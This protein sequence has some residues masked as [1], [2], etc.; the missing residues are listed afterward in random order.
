VA[1]TGDKC[2]S[3][4]GV[5]WFVFLQESTRIYMI[6]DCGR[7]EKDKA[8]FFTTLCVYVSDGFEETTGN[9]ERTT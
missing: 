1:V 7:F 6:C 2:T 8:V 5:K 9:T 4:C 3:V